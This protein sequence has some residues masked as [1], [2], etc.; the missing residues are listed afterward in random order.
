MRQTNFSRERRHVERALQFDD[1]LDCFEMAD[2]L[3]HH[4]E[5]VFSERLA[6]DAA[7]LIQFAMADRAQTAAE[8]NVLALTSE[9]VRGRRIMTARALWPS[10]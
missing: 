6:N 1:E 5:I 9:L 10:N 2:A 4:R 8:L 3:F 7:A